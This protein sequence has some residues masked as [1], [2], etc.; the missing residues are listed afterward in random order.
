MLIEPWSRARLGDVASLW[1]RTRPDEP[2]S[3]EELNIVLCDDGGQILGDDDGTACIAFAQGTGEAADRG[4]IRLLVVAPER[5][6]HGVGQRLLAAAERSL[7]GNGVRRVRLAAG[8]P[9]YLWPGIDVTNAPARRLA[10]GAGYRVV[11]SAVNMALPTSMELPTSIEAHVPRGVALRPLTQADSSALGALMSDHWPI[12][13]TECALALEHGRVFGAWFGGA[14]VG[15][16]AHSAMRRGWISP[17]GIIPEAA[18]QGIG[19]AL[20]AAVCA[21]L[22]R[23]G[24]DVATIAW[25]GPTDFFA[26][27]GAKVSHRFERWERERR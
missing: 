19:S 15:F 8:V 14:L 12:W 6:R 2:L 7:H 27:H 26:H 25:V 3:V 24:F 23:A 20:L 17:M 4:N 9:R 18:G 22:A 11:D 13:S 21:D 16:A 5:Q 10:H 1:N